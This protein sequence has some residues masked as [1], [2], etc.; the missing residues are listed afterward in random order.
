MPDALGMARVPPSAAPEQMDRF[1]CDVGRLR[2]ALDGLAAVHRLTGGHRLHIAALLRATH[3]LDDA[4]E[5]R[6]LDVGAG[7]GEGTAHLLRRLGRRA[8]EAWAVLA[9]LH[10]VTLR[11]AR[12]RLSG[13]L[14]TGA[15]GNGENLRFVRLT[16]G[17]LP[18]AD[19][20]FDLAFSSTT[21][22]H[23]E[24]DEAVAFLGELDRVSRGRWAVTDLRRSRLTLALVRLL[25]ATL[26]RR[27]P[28]PRRDGPLSVRRSFTPGEL[29]GL[30][31]A[32]GL[33]GARV[34][35]RGPV[36]MRAVGRG[37]PA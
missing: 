18:F 28:F 27:N 20:A 2:R 37:V 4:R 32:A 23:L 6:I 25:A 30:I 9:D 24:W 1:D 7:G 11:L 22:H 13:G 21:L 14:P 3:N 10:P 31:G 34:D 5:I 29:A 17:S 33:S 35:R 8:R 15:A 16:A 19:G 26:W 12:E 36:R